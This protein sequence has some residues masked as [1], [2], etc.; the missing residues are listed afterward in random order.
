MSPQSIATAAK[1]GFHE[2]CHG[3]K[4]QGPGV[5]LDEPGASHRLLGHL[6]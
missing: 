1:G 4:I 3:R 5:V 2:D 6:R